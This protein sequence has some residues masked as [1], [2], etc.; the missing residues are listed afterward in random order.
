MTIQEY[1]G[2]WSNVVDL[3]EADRIIKKLSASNCVICP[4]L[5]DI[6]KAFTLCPLNN[7]RVILLSQDPYPNLRLLRQDSILQ[8]V[9]VAT[10]LAFANSSDTPDTKLSPSL[11]IL[12]ES[13]INYTIPHRTINFDPSLE[14]WEAQGVLLLNS[15]LSCEVGKVGSHTLLWRP[16][17]K[18]LLTNLS[19]YHTGLVYVL[20]GTQAQT[21]EPYINK[22]FNHV[23]R[24]RHPS[25]YARQRQRMS[26]DI[27]QGINSILIS[28]NGYGIEWF[29]E[30]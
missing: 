8:K 30:Y 11:E 25:W 1:F 3:K 4:Q 2:D 17:I 12:K 22:Q 13:V 7:L 18:S 23:I 14:K 16:F 19:I 5:K 6:F 27:W 15:A 29:M 26:S 21:L 20:M 28:Q 9:P 24:I 10:G